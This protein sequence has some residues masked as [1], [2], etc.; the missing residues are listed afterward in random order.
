MTHHARVLCLLAGLG[1]ASISVPTTAQPAFQVKDINTSASGGIQVLGDDAVTVAGIAFFAASDGVVGAEL[2]RSDGTAAGTRRVKDVCPGSCPSNPLFLTALGTELYFSADDG[3]HGRELW[4]SDGTEAGTVLVKDVTPGL[5]SSGPGVLTAVNG[6]IFF[7]ANDGVHGQEPWVSDGTDVGTTLLADV[8]PGALGSSPWP[9]ATVGSTLFFSADDGIHGGELWKTDGTPLGTAMVKDI[10]PGSGSSLSSGSPFFFPKAAA[11]GGQLLFAADDGTHGI[12]L[13]TSDGT[14]MGT[15]LLA[16]LVPGSGGANPF[17]FVV[18][19]TLVFF[20]ANDPV[21]GLEL[22]ASDGTPGGSGRVKD[23]N[24][25]TASSVPWEL[26]AVGSQVFFTASDGAHGRELW[27]SDGTDAG[28][29]MVKDVNPGAG[30][31]AYI[32]TPMRLTASGSRLFLFANDGVNGPEPWVSDG[33][34]AGTT[35]LADLNP[36]P[37]GSFLGQGFGISRSTVAGGRWFFTAYT[38]AT[39]SE[40]YVSDGTPAG[41]TL[42]ADVDHQ[43]SAFGLSFFSGSLIEPG[44]LADLSGTLFFQATD[45]IS[46]QE[47]WKSNGTPGGTVQ[48]AD[49]VPGAVG[50]SPVELTAV[51]G[52]LFFAAQAT[53]SNELWTTDGTTNTRLAGNLDTIGG[54]TA[55][56]GTLLFVADS[57]AQGTELWKSDGT[58]GGTGLL[59]D[60]N[61]GP[62]PSFP[63]GFTA[64]GSLALFSAAGPEGQELWRTDGTAAGTVLVKDVNPGAGDSSPVQ[65]TAALG[66]VFFSADDGVHGAELWASD[67]TA[68]GTAL[69]KDVQPGTGNS[70]PS[71]LA[72][73][74]TGLLFFT[75]DDGVHGAELW[76]SDGNPANPAGT[77]MVA[78]I[79]PGSRS[80]EILWMTAAVDRVYFVAEDGV[81]GRELWVSDGTAAGTHMVSD[82][83]PGPGSGL[84]Q[85][86]HAIGKRIV[87][88]AYDGVHGRELWRSNGMAAG[89]ILLQD[90]N[91]GPESS[92]PLG[93]TD[94][95]GNVYFVANDGTTGFELWA[96]PRAAVEGALDFYTVPPC[97]VFDTRGGAPLAAGVVRSFAVAGSCGLPATAK[98]VAANLTLVQPSGPGFLKVYPSGGPVPSTSTLNV[99]PLSTRSN[100]ALLALGAG[101][102]DAVLG[103]TGAGMAD[104][105]L[106]VYGYFE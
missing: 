84:P 103:M 89:T 15:G 66:R 88:S 57:T 11:L 27:K 22:W 23:I 92:S 65:L 28:T 87:F 105:V 46:G 102:L 5:G 69:V 24:P 10:N 43:A 37:Q 73:T 59:K 58:P 80:S 76:V 97:R 74:T 16:D 44:A 93:F 90:L 6:R 35:L 81:H 19:G 25:G 94:S 2:W 9:L 60:I 38:P 56:G 54:L 12:E 33:T 36:G 52:A 71:Q 30:D 77:V 86:L 64:L 99:N 96:L 95:G 1:L 31:S 39:A 53:S 61:P 13:W 104:L 47:L 82:I 48:V 83:L 75:A 4:K 3:A 98:V 26:T 29:V 106:D 32:F 14:A 40:I 21:H 85:D 68:A 62:S 45:G 79:F 67:G 42:V 72:A 34:D 100:N 63:E 51:G 49:L 101:G 17:D 18:A 55:F 41:T 20:Q 7:F 8:L 70:F 78:D 50:S 91:P